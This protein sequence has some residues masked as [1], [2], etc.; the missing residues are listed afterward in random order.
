LFE[1]MVNASEFVMHWPN[2]ASLSL[3]GQH[4]LDNESIRHEG[5]SNEP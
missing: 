2:F 4:R 3:R 1:N 5:A